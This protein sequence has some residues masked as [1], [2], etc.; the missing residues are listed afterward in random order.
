[1]LFKII[2][3]FKESV[4]EITKEPPEKIQEAISY[5]YSRLLKRADV[6]RSFIR[7]QLTKVLSLEGVIRAVRVSQKILACEKMMW[8]F[9]DNI[10]IIEPTNNFAERQIR[11]FVIYRKNS[12]FVW[13]DR[14]LEFIERI[15]SIFMTSNL[16]NENPFEN[17]RKIIGG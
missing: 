7:N 12:F 9:I 8:K 6:V 1:M 17:L 11:N 16:R 13:S 15:H 10:F 5:F 3:N 14:G 4:L 2:R